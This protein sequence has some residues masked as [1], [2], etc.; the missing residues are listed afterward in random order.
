MRAAGAARE[1][2]MAETPISA[3]QSRVVA[4]LG[5]E[6]DGSY[7]H[8][9]HVLAAA[10]LPSDG[11]PSGH[12]WRTVKKLSDDAF[13]ALLTPDAEQASRVGAYESSLAR[14]QRLAAEAA[15]VRKER[16][17]RLVA[18]Q[19]GETADRPL[20]EQAPD[21]SLWEVD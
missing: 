13:R 20:Y 1:D 2:E 16:S 11:V 9:S 7:A 14:S 5:L 19:R 21:G 3:T 15:Q 4:L 8:A 17:A 18:W 10:G 12:T 6:T